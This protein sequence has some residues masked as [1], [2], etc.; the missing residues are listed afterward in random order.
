MR[1]RPYRPDGVEFSSDK[2]LKQAIKSILGYKPGNIFLYHLAFLHKSATQETNNGIKINNERLEFLGDAVLKYL[3]ELKKT[4]ERLV[5][6]T[7]EQGLAVPGTEAQ[8]ANLTWA[9][10]TRRFAAYLEHA[11]VYHN[12]RQKG[13]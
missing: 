1:F 2:E 13:G 7:A 11:F 3:D 4:A 12:R 6:R 5:R 10:L 9:I 8:Q